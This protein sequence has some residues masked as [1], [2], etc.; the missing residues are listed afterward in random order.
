MR[1]DGE[2]LQQ[3]VPRYKSARADPLQVTPKSL[4]NQQL[5]GNIF[6][7]LHAVNPLFDT[8]VESLSLHPHLTFTNIGEK[9]I[10][11]SLGR[12]TADL[13][14]SVFESISRHFVI[15]RIILRKYVA[16]LETD[17]IEENLL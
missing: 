14:F 2:N 13:Y 16:Y 4:T 11:Q 12:R 10:D 7:L 9:V 17:R 1:G 8:L 15:N 5:R 3:L 6:R